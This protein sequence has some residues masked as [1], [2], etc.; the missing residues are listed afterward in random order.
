[1]HKD[2][3]DRVEHRHESRRGDLGYSESR[4]RKENQVLLTNHISP[5]YDRQL[6]VEPVPERFTVVSVVGKQQVVHPPP[7]LSTQVHF[8]GLLSVS[9]SATE[10]PHEH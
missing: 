6:R 10:R 3:L 4:T 9:H 5:S 7:R 2:F 8:R 1:M